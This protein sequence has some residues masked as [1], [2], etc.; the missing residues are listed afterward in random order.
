MS[1]KKLSVVLL[2]H[3]GVGKT[4]MVSLVCNNRPPDYYSPTV[5]DLHTTILDRVLLEITDTSANEFVASSRKLSIRNADAI[6][7]V[8]DIL[9]T[10]TALALDKLMEEVQVA[11]HRPRSMA[12]HHVVIMVVGVKVASGPMNKTC[13]EQYAVNFARFW[14][15]DYVT[16]ILTGPYV[17]G[18]FER[19]IY[20][21]R[22]KWQE[23][24]Q[25]N[26]RI[27][28]NKEEYKKKT[29][30]FGWCLCQGTD[31]CLSRQ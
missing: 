10:N 20:L 1:R 22:K 5:E 15:T 26:E 6:I 25:N 31:T 13:A 2:G 16:T 9:K 29:R 14:D 28:R 27:R 18:V 23:I 17:K 4:T 7:F 8:Y 12:D 3:T 21:V 19:C 11:L 30:I 24:G